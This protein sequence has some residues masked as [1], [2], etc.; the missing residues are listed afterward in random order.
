MHI[1]A[2]YLPEDKPKC[3]KEIDQLV[4]CMMASAEITFYYKTSKWNR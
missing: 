1:A 4:F 3:H 2:T